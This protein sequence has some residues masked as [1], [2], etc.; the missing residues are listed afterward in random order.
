MLNGGDF[1]EFFLREKNPRKFPSIMILLRGQ[2][3]GVVSNIR[4]RYR[5]IG[6]SK[7]TILSSKHARYLLS[8]ILHFMIK[9]ST[10]L[11]TRYARYVVSTIIFSS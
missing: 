10:I 2:G 9:T 1:G 11:M 5:T 3:C 4:V 6:S 8:H 7:H